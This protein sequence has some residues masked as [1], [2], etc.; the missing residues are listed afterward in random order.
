MTAV[1]RTR[2]IQ[3]RVVEHRAARDAAEEHRTPVVQ[4]AEGV[5]PS[6]PVGEGGGW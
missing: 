3:V 5:A 2:V 4:R 6:W 1:S